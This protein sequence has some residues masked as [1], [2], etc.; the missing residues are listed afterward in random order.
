M[1]KILEFP[2][3]REFLI[4]R[5]FDCGVRYLR[6]SAH[7]HHGY[8]W[9]YSA[10]DALHFTDRAEA[11]KLLARITGGGVIAEVLKV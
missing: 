3:K 10:R 8:V 7:S 9:T 4:A 11:E 1:A 6:K 2:A 5:E